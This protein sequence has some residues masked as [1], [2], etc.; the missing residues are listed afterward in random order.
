MHAKDGFKESIPFSSLL[1]EK[2]VEQAHKISLHG[3]L[4]LT[5]A[6]IREKFWIPRL[7]KLTKR[8]LKSCWGCK[9]FRATPFVNPSIAPLPNRTHGS[10]AFDVIGVN[11]A[12]PIMYRKQRNKEAK[13]YVVLYS[14]SLTCTV[15]LELLSY[16]EVGEFLQSLKR[17][18]ASRGRRSKIYSDNAKTFLAGAKWQENVQRDEHFNEFLVG[19][20]IVWQ[21]NLSRA[22]WWGGHF[23][24]LIGLMKAAFYKVVGQGSLSWTELTEVLLDIEITLNNRPLTYMEED[25]QLPPLT[26]NLLLFINTNVLLELAPYHLEEKNIRKRAKFLQQCKRAVWKRWTTKYLRALREQHRLKSGGTGRTITEGEVVIIKS[27]N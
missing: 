8:V 12:G 17:L 11:F 15:Y 22:P 21:F 4:T 6:K 23:E 10:S 20:S 26:P 2:M 27:T 5:M 9:R 24:R 14:F 13:A 16:L 19:H 18:I 7:C 25:V 3:G 1:G